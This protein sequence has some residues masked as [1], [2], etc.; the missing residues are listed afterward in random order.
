MSDELPLALDQPATTPSLPTVAGTLRLSKKCLGWAIAIAAISD[1]IS[2]FVTLA[3]PI[4]WV[5]D[6]VTAT[7]LFIVLGWHWLLLPGLILE[8]IPG[9]GVMPF[10]LLVVG[11]VAVWGTPRPRLK[12]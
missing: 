8:A 9:V 3:P 4:V 12:R 11:A 5:G 2:A 7:L 10:W 1:A 6:L